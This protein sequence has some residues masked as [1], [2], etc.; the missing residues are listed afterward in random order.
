MASM[1]DHQKVNDQHNRRRAVKRPTSRRYS[2]H[3]WKSAPGTGDIEGDKMENK[4]SGL[5]AAIGTEYRVSDRTFILLG[6][7]RSFKK[8][9][10]AKRPF[11]MMLRRTMEVKV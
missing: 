4:R 3:L 11:L 1:I 7:E 10:S 5:K 8:E 6:A 9:K 2:S